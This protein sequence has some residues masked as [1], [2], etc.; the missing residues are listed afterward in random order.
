MQR[1]PIRD[2]ALLAHEDHL[3]PRMAWMAEEPQTLEQRRPMLEKRESESL[4]G[5]DVMLV[6][7]VGDEVAGSCGLHRRR[8]LWR[9]AS[10]R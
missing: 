5:G 10:W 7:F 3:R 9:S 1:E 6:I 4:Q 8:L 2:G